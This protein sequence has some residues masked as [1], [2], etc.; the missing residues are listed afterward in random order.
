MIMGVFLFCCFF[1]LLKKHDL[2]IDSGKLKAKIIVGSFG[3]FV[4]SGRGFMLIPSFLSLQVELRR[5]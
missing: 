3:M 4:G 2:S 1:Y 5:I